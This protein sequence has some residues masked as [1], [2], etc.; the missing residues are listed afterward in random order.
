[1]CLCVLFALGFI[2]VC[3]WF[4]FKFKFVTFDIVRVYTAYCTEDPKSHVLVKNKQ[5]V[6]SD[7]NCILVNQY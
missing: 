1:M 2:A 6:I 4:E 3:F 7:A 5:M